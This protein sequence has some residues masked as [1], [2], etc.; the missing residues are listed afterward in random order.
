[1]DL[2]AAIAAACALSP[3]RAR[4]LLGSLFGMIEDDLTAR[5][6]LEAG[7]C[8]ITEL[9]EIE[10]WRFDALRYLGRSGRVTYGAPAFPDPHATATEAVGRAAEARLQIESIRAMLEALYALPN[11]TPAPH[12]EPSRAAASVPP[13]M[14]GFL[15]LRLSPLLLDDVLDVVPMLSPLRRV[16]GTEADREAREPRP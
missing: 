14:L 9:P 3:D 7:R 10:A 1:M 12:P 2:V 5:R 16:G 13:L 15:R 8:L 6:G 11:A 4:A